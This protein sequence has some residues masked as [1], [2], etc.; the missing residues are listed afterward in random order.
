MSIPGKPMEGAGEP[1][2]IREVKARYEECLLSMP[3]V[4]SVGIG[5][6]SD[7]SPVIVVGLDRTRAAT[8]GEIPEEL[9]GY[10]VRVEMVGKVRAL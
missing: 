6:G 2:S 3:G 1:P 7:G 5:R 8:I 10:P 9:E 4:V